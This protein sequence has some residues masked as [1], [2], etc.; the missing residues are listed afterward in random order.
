MAIRLKG[1]GRVR[2]ADARG[3]ARPDRLW[4][5]AAICS[6]GILRAGASR[7][8]C[9]AWIGTDQEGVDPSRS[10]RCTA[11]ILRNVAFSRSPACRASISAGPSDHIGSVPSAV[12]PRP[13]RAALRVVTPWDCAPHVSGSRSLGRALPQGGRGAPAPGPRDHLAGG[14]AEGARHR[15]ERVGE[16]SNSL[17]EPS[18]SRPYSWLPRSPIRSPEEGR[19]RPFRQ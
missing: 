1:E 8:P 2:Q 15:R 9:P 16:K 3:G 12:P 13:V 17:A 10:R 14:S 18:E 5:R 19:W 11:S 7:R 6:G 4:V